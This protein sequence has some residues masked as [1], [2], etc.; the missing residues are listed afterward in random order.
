MR[1]EDIGRSET[2][3]IQTDKYCMIFFELK[4]SNSWLPGQGKRWE[5]RVVLV[6]DF[7]FQL[8]RRNRFRSFCIDGR[9]NSIGLYA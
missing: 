4:K 1:P 5:V 9:V 2:S 7:K 8:Y 6:K 3:H